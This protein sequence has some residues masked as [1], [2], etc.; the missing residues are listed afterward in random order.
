MAAITIRNL[1]ENLKRRLRQRAAEHERSM[2]G[3]VRAILQ[4]ALDPPSPAERKGLGAEIR[5][6]VE[7]FGAADDLE[8]LPDEQAEPMT[9]E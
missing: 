4:A 9:F 2:E 3:E 6:L 5:A 7:Q 8:L 1:D